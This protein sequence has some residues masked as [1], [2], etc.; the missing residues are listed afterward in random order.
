MYY[1]EGTVLLVKNPFVFWDY[2]SEDTWWCH[3]GDNIVLI[4]GVHFSPHATFLMLN[5]ERVTLLVNDTLRMTTLSEMS[6]FFPHTN[7]ILH[8]S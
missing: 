5:A 8:G 4:D 3:P 1:P 2:F 7:V 6:R